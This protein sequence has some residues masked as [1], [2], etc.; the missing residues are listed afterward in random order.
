[1]KVST[2]PAQNRDRE[3]AVA[4]T[5]LITFATYATWLP[6]QPGAV[7]RLHN[8]FGGRLPEASPTVAAR[9]TERM[10]QEPYLLDAIRRQAVLEAVQQVCSHRAWAL[11]AAH[12]RS[13]HVHVVVAA[14]RS[15]EYVMN[16]LKAYASRALNQMGIDG[17]E[18][19]R[20]ARHGSTRHLWTSTSVS[21]AVRYVVSGQGEAMAVYEAPA[22]AR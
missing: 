6:G 1:M 7:D 13:N 17:P 12:V 21:A 3:G 5:Y 15:A 4:A 22:A 10:S 14:D 2:P 19:R 9:V 18:R 20:W 8:M 11:L 16:T